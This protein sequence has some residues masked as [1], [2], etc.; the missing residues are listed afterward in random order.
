MSHRSLA[1]FFVPV[2]QQR[3]EATWGA[4][5]TTS[6]FS[7]GAWDCLTRYLEGGRIQ[8]SKVL[9]CAAALA[10]RSKAPW[11]I[12]VEISWAF[13][14]GRLSMADGSVLD[15]RTELEVPSSGEWAILELGCNTAED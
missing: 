5:G 8:I 11:P 15:C 13:A 1:D 6:L 12:R 14:R 2:G 7:D 9:L 10:M 4:T 3:G